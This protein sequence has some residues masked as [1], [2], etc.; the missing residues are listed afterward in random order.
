MLLACWGTATLGLSLSGYFERFD[1]AALMIAGLLPTPAY[2]L[3]LL[4]SE[5]FR[6]FVNS[7]DVRR[8]TI[9]EAG[10]ILGGTAFGLAAWMHWMSMPFA[11]FTA[12]S[13][14]VVGV[15]AFW[16]VRRLWKR[17]PRAFALWHIAGASCLLGAGVLGSLTSPAVQ[18][19]GGPVTSQ[20]VSG[21][22]YSLVPIFLGP[23]MY[24]CHWI[25]LTH[26]FG[27]TA[28][29]ERSSGSLLCGEGRPRTYCE[30]DPDQS[31][32]PAS[33]RALSQTQ[34][35]IHAFRR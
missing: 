16:A 32:C 25:P 24:M 19:I 8:V 5:H 15:S 27:S 1:A 22:P 31:S 17:H 23:M 13:D 11:A 18:A 30:P 14:I 12:V 6:R 7:L 33:G 2:F 20:A 34:V 26:G 3:A 4:S 35:E 29:V 28:P 9:L 10:R 21:F